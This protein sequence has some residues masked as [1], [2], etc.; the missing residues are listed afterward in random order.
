MCEATAPPT[1]LQW[2]PTEQ[3]DKVYQGHTGSRFSDC[4][5]NRNERLISLVGD[6]VAVELICQLNGR[7]DYRERDYRFG[8]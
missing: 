2:S 5:T 6:G 7:S 1:E 8:D 4:D 3:D